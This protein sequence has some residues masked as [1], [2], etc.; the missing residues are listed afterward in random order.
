MNNNLIKVSGLIG[1]IFGGIAFALGS[2]ILFI[3]SIA[4]GINLILLSQRPR[5]EICKK[6][7][8][9]IIIACLSLI[10]CPLISILLFISLD[11][12]KQ[13]PDQNAPPK[14]NSNNSNKK[15]NKPIN[16]MKVLL[17][18]GT[19][20]ISISGIL[21]ATTNWDTISSSTKVLF[22]LFAALFFYAMS[23]L[24]DKKFNLADLSNTYFVLS[25]TFLFITTIS[26]S[27]FELLGKWLSYNGMGKNLLISIN[28]IEAAFISTIISNKV[29]SKGLM[30]ITYT[31]LYIATYFILTFLNIEKNVI[32][33]IL[34]TASF[35]INFKGNKNLP[36]HLVEISKM[37]MYIYPI[38]I[39][40]NYS[41]DIYS[42][43][44]V[45]SLYILFGYYQVLQ[46]RSDYKD[47]IIMAWSFV[48]SSVL[49]EII[50]GTS[51]QIIAYIILISLLYLLV[52]L[53]KKDR[54][55]LIVNKILYN[56]F[57]AFTTLVSLIN[58]EPITSFCISLIYLVINFLFAEKV[59]N[60]KPSIDYSILQPIA[61]LMFLSITNSFLLE[62]NIDINTLD[63]VSL[64][65]P[66]FILLKINKD[67]KE[68]LNIH[69][70][71][72]SILLLFSINIFDPSI[73]SI[74]CLIFG[75]IYLFMTSGNTVVKKISYGI[76]LLSVMLLL[77]NDIFEIPCYCKDLIII[78]I[79]V[80]S[81]IIAEKNSIYKKISQALLS[82]CILLFIEDIEVDFTVETIL[83]NLLLVYVLHLIISFFAKND[84]AKNILAA[85]GMSIIM[86]LVVFTTDIVI[87][88]Y[89]GILAL[90]VILFGYYK[91]EYSYLFKVGITAEI[92]NVIYQLRTL[93]RAIPF[94]L[95]LLL[96]GLLI[97]G[98]VTYKELKKENDKEKRVK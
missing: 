54:H 40:M 57:F 24:A 53:L 35:L 96:S 76:S 7:T 86:L 59:L 36:K 93:W 1:L 38:F 78:W 4:V 90:I 92:V 42:N 20:L 39:L 98:F 50:S 21:F 30:Y 47:N 8:T 97:V 14:E 89:L 87:C 46:D 16:K 70:L 77:K 74:I 94:W 41:E 62:N 58:Q 23:Y 11:R 44:L 27:Y 65:I 33:S 15:E 91:K 95:Y 75:T 66:I 37:S 2:N 85:V 17:Q 88:I 84:K 25:I 56:V 79:Y 55:T 9:I 61:V 81:I 80:I 64:S 22:L 31:S 51:H 67:K 68:Y 34:M 19:L 69:G 48:L 32:I 3:V 72:I 82:I 13:T 18:L 83:I 52:E 10:I 63:F 45:I 28:F 12:L 60:K 6:K 43:L 71:L 26:I 5:E 29:N 73:L 49:L